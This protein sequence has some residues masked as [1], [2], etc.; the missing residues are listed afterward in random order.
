M[1]MQT[2]RGDWTAHDLDSLPEDGNRYEIIDGELFVSPSPSLRH[3]DAVFRLHRILAEYLE[4]ERIAYVYSAPADVMFAPRRTV[5]PDVFVVPLVNGRRPPSAREIRGLLMAIEVVSPGSARADR[6]NKRALYRDEQVAEY[7][8]ID[9]DS[10]TIERS[11]PDEAR[12]EVL[13]D[14]LEWLPDGASTPL[15]INL[16]TYFAGIL[17][18]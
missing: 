1:H 18:E 14:R 13:A 11:T 4:R 6:V 3:Q 12:P 10:R 9:L 8:I 7:W 5:Q 15:V 16:A 17:D 2:L